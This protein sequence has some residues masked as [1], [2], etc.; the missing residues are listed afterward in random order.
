MVGS[1]TPALQKVA[2]AMFLKVMAK[3]ITIEPEWVA[4]SKN[5]QAN[6]LSRLVDWD[7]WQLHPDIF[8][9]LEL[10]P[11]SVDRFASYYNTQLPQFNSRFWNLGTKA[12]NDFTCNW[13]DELNWWCPHLIWSHGQ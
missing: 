12:V 13:Q 7:D 1:K 10:G 3:H 8:G 11:H 4:H 6:Y 5:Q 2:F 9:E